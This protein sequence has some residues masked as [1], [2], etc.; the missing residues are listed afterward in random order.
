MQ[1]KAE[2]ILGTRRSRG[3]L[4]LAALLLVF[5]AGCTT[6]RLRREAQL[7]EAREDWDAAVV[8]YLDLVEQ[9]PSNVRYKTAL[10][11]AKIRASQVHFD[12]GRRFHEAGVL[13]D[14]TKAP[15]ESVWSRGPAP[16]AAPDKVTH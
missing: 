15:D 7:A 12:K 11:R 5:L 8:H 4:A 14:P 9:E 13:E 16:Q 3:G 10:L 6:Y 1:A 2:W